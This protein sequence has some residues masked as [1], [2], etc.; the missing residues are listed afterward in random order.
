MARAIVKDRKPRIGFQGS[1]E[2]EKVIEGFD[3]LLKME[4]R[5][6]CL[7][8]IGFIS[9]ISI[10]N[11]FAL[12]AV[13]VACPTKFVGTVV[14]V[15]ELSSTLFPKIS[16]T[17]ETSERLKGEVADTLNF[18]IVKGGP[19]KFD[20]KKEYV[21]EMHDGYLCQATVTE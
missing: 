12:S 2:G 14:E 19:I 16:V 8:R 4:L 1:Q 20:P 18:S 9:L 11:S 10:N 15:K 5:M 3:H 17:V 21:F 13:N 6:R 7:I